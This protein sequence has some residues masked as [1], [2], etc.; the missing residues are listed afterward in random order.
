MVS[1]ALPSIGGID[2]RFRADRCIERPANSSHNGWLGAA[3]LSQKDLMDK[4]RV[5]SELSRVRKNCVT[6]VLD[7]VL[8]LELT[9]CRKAASDR[10]RKSA[11][12]IGSTC[13]SSVR[14]P[15]QRYN[16]RLLKL[17]CCG[18][19]AENPPPVLWPWFVLIPKRAGAFEEQ[20]LLGVAICWYWP[21]SARYAFVARR[22]RKVL[23]NG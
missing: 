20:F 21:R 5:S 19:D 13:Y 12:E 10:V 2:Q 11:F 3:T 18:E 17:L 9:H 23:Q 7:V 14:M 16:G 6:L 1:D 15:Q 22:F 8:C 4:E